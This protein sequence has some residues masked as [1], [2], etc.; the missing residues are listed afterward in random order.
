LAAKDY[1]IGAVIETIVSS[2]QFRDVR[3]REMP[4]ED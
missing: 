4:S 2:R 1:R 3:G